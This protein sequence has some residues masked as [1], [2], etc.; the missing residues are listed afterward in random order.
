MKTRDIDIRNFLNSIILKKYKNDPDTKIVNEFNICHGN[1]RIDIAVINGSIIGYEIKSDSDTLQRLPKQIELYNKV[2]D[3]V[4]IISGEVYIDRIMNLVPEW[5]G[6]IEVVGGKKGIKNHIY[7]RKA[8]NNKSVDAHSVSQLLWKNEALELLAKYNLS[9]GLSN[10]TIKILWEKVVD[11]IPLEK[12]QEFV[13]L[14]LKNRS[15]WR[16]DKQRIQCAGLSRSVPKSLDFRLKNLNRL[17]S[18]ISCDRQR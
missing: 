18:Q 13:R 2:F 3:K 10:K 15:N 16:V 11:N 6:V 7:I 1:A 14:K 12:I 5:W 8:T 17:L 9:R 4:T